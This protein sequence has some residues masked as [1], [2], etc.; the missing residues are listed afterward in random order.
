MRASVCRH[1]FVRVYCG[2]TKQRELI[3]FVIFQTGFVHFLW[4]YHGIM[5]AAAV[6][7][8]AATS[9]SESASPDRPMMMPDMAT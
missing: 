7:V 9:A 4:Y 8:A 2:P 3:L 6:S 5:F 1:T